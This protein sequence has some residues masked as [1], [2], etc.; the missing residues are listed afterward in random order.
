[1]NPPTLH[2]HDVG[3]LLGLL[4][5]MWLMHRRALPFEGYKGIV[6]LMLAVW[7]YLLVALPLWD[8]VHGQHKDG[9]SHDGIYV[10]TGR[11]AE[12]SIW[13]IGFCAACAVRHNEYTPGVLM[14]ATSVLVLVVLTPELLSGLP[15]FEL[16][17]GVHIWDQLLDDK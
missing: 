10:L 14:L 17:F 3:A 12:L 11:Y 4:P 2:I 9:R 1:M 16:V 5:W 7:F 13:V 8:I 6:N 15:W